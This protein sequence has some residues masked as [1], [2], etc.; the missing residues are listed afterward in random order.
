MKP[1]VV[2]PEP[3]AEP[4]LRLLQGRC[5]VECGPHAVQFLD[6]ADGVLVRLFRFGKEEFSRSPR[7][8]VIAKHGVGTDN[9]DVGAATARRI[10]VVFTPAANAN[11]VAEHAIT[12]M[13]A[14]S[15]RIATADRAVREGKW[16][17]RPPLE[18]VELVDKKLGV[19][20]LGRVGS[21]VARIAAA[22]LGMNVIAF[23][24]MIQP[25]NYDGPATLVG[26]I[27]ELLPECDFLTLHVPL[28]SQTNQ[29]LGRGNLA[30]LKPGCRIVNTSRG[31]VIDEAALVEALQRGTIAGA[32]LDVFENEP[33]PTDH[34]LC[35][36]PNVLLTPHVSSSTR[37]S[38]ERMATHAAQGVVDVLEG[39][40]PSY[41]V[42]PEVLP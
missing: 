17:D 18:G 26:S 35:R 16:T 38:L 29:L 6:R 4:G 5:E 24:P 22:G 39:R 2:L 25:G 33:L 20:G 21:R 32:A 41:P 7:L 27:D 40:R 9:I 15:R 19:V 1:L 28:T 12:L 13:L 10:P 3:I 34:P 8:K 14:L 37:E 11:A 23:D 42:N 36:A 31:Q 30:R